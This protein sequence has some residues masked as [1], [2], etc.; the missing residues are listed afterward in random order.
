MTKVYENKC[1]NK[2]WQKRGHSKNRLSS[3]K[4]AAISNLKSLLKSLLNFSYFGIWYISVGAIPSNYIIKILI[5][6]VK[7]HSFATVNFF[8]FDSITPSIFNQKT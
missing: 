2:V 7:I 6:V 5:E 8:S 1:G 4:K 3:P